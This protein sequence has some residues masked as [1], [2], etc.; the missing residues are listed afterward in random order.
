MLVLAICTTFVAIVATVLVYAT[1][2]WLVSHAIADGELV[3]RLADDA[4]VCG[5]RLA[6]ALRFDYVRSLRRDAP[7]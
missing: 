1:A 3:G 2:A 7:P 6:Q 4:R 5:A